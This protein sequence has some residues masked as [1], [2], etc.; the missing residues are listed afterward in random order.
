MKKRIIS[1]ALVSIMVILLAFS[2]CSCRGKDEPKSLG[3][4]VT[5]YVTIKIKDYGTIELELY[6][7]VAPITVA[8]FVDLAESGFYDGLT[9]HRIISDFM[10]QGGGFEVD[11][12][13]KE[14]D[15]I[16]GEFIANGVSNPINHVRGVISMARADSM[17]SGS[18]QFFI[19][20]QDSPHLDGQYAAFGIVTKGIAVVDKICQEVPQGYNGSV[21]LANRPVI[22]SITVKKA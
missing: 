2:L 16:K 20:H 19:M 11:G 1:I 5:H 9:F 10:I 17:N 8:N 4:E 12:T 22:E 15:N 6:G 3:Y 14:A 7:K 18:S 21:T 13:Y